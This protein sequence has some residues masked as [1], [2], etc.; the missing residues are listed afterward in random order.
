MNAAIPNLTLHIP[1]EAAQYWGLLLGVGVLLAILGIVAIARAV[2]ATIF[3]MGFFGW[4][5]LFSSA[6]MA[7]SAFLVGSWIGFFAF[8]L[9]AVLFGVLGF[10]F[11]TKPILSAESVTLLMAAYF[12]VFGIFEVLAPLLTHHAGWGYALAN[13]G[14]NIFLGLLLFRQFPASGLFTVGLFLGINLIFDGLRLATVALA[15]KGA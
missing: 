10:L 11:I 8:L 14:I 1:H 13:G 4:L 5:L 6:S 2:K 7:V 9:S 15:A 3:A 12:L